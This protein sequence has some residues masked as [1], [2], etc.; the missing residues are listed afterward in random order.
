MKPEF[1]FKDIEKLIKIITN[2]SKKE[3][4]KLRVEKLIYFIYA[5]YGAFVLEN[6]EFPKNLIDI[7]FTNDKYG[8][9]IVGLSDLLEK[10]YS[11]IEI[12]D[13]HSDEDLINYLEESLTDLEIG[14]LE[15]IIDIVR[16]TDTMGDF[17]LVEIN[18]ADGIWIDCFNNNKKFSNK[19][20][21][22]EYALK[23]IKDW[24]PN[25]TRLFF[26]FTYWQL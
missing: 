14:A 6:E 21:Y 8:F 24:K 17:T 11:I 26:Y 20:L 7:Q 18:H 25:D 19:D 1:L 5:Y 22:S 9:H 3:M 15:I 10:D 13:Y 12:K 2:L 4:T 23:I 16:Q